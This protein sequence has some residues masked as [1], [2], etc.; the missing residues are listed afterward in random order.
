MRYGWKWGRYFKHKDIDCDCVLMVMFAGRE[1]EFQ[2]EV[3]V[4]TRCMFTSPT[5]HGHGGLSRGTHQKVRHTC[6]RTLDTYNITVFLTTQSTQDITLSVLNPAV[7]H[8]CFFEI[9]SYI[10]F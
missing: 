3:T 9:F 5:G 6:S 4:D 10:K 7:G 1:E 2:G 8:F